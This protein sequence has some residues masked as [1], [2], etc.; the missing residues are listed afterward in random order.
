MIVDHHS[1]VLIIGAGPGGYET[2]AAA[3]SSG[4]SVRIIERDELGGTCLNRGCIPTKCLC[5]SA[6]VVSV[7]S[8]ACS[9]GVEVQ[10]YTLDYGRAVSRM[11]STV[12]TLREGVAAALSG[13]DVIKAEASFVA[14]GMVAAGDKVYTAGKI[15]IATGSRPAI[16]RIEGAE[17][18]VTSDDVLSA[19]SLPG[20]AV[21]I[22]GGVIGMEL[23]CIMAAFGT[24]VSVLEY[25][26]EILPAF[27]KDISKRLRSII[28]QKAGID[29]VTGAKVASVSRSPEGS[30]NVT[31]DTKRGSE[32]L[33]T[34]MVVMAT[35]R[36]PVI[37]EGCAEA[38]I[39]VGPAGIVTGDN[40]ETTA[41]GVYAIGDC[42][43][44]C[45]LAHAASAQ[46][47]I[48]L[49]LDVVPDVIPAAVFT[50]PEAAMVGLTEAQCKDAGLD[51]AVGKSMFGANGKAV[52][53]GEPVG[54]VKMI[55]RRDTGL[56]LGVHI[57]GPHAS[58]LIQE[59]ATVMASGLGVDAIARA[60][61]AH[62][63]LG[64][65]VVMAAMNLKMKL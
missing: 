40:M 14:P 26:K 50:S 31:F 17:Y 3:A 34:D 37:P 56:L 1:D 52:A 58:D 63:T 7:V 20:N 53:M 61:H 5:R 30:F 36:R 12:A 38:G 25:C 8:D 15:I 13:V 43:G 21:I 47:R 23:A 2:A 19:Q 27:D 11:R 4:L 28:G 54:M 35:G 32:A 64:E 10:G 48:V 41:S 57:L 60:I 16:P 18:T 33:T 51:Y 42:N 44:R 24:K 22:G 59:A 29:I 45:M 46:G 65:A 6:E 9:Y 39:E 62:P 49:G 55:C